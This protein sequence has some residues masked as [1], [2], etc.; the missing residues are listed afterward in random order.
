MDEFQNLKKNSTIVYDD[1]E[2]SSIVTYTDN[3]IPDLRREDPDVSSKYMNLVKKASICIF[4]IVI[5]CILGALSIRPEREEVKPVPKMPYIIEQ[6]YNPKFIEFRDYYLVFATMIKNKRRYVREW[7]EFHMMMGITYFLVYDNYSEDGTREL[8]E[9]YIQNGVVSYMLWPPKELPLYNWED[10]KLE[11]HFKV[12]MDTCLNDHSPD[13]NHVQCQEAAFDDATRRSRGK[14]KW[15]ASVDIDEFYYVPESSP[16]ANL[17]DPLPSV[18]KKLE[19]YKMIYLDGQHF[20]TSGFLSPARRNDD[21]SFASLIT[22][23]HL[24]HMPYKRAQLVIAGDH[25]KPFVDPYCV[26]G[27]ELHDYGYDEEWFKEFP[28][29]IMNHNTIAEENI[30]IYMNHFLWPSVSETAVKVKDNNN[31]GT[32]YDRDYDCVINKEEGSSIEYLL[33]RL[34]KR[35]ETAVVNFPPA[36]SHA[37]DWDFTLSSRHVYKQATKVDLCIAIMHPRHIGLVRHALTSLIYY[38][39]NV[40]PSL[41]YYLVVYD[42][43]PEFDKELRTDFPIDSFQKNA[44]QLKDICSS[45]EYILTMNEASFAR[46]EAWPKEL[47]VIEFALQLIYKHPKIEGVYLGDSKNSI[48]EWEVSEDNKKAVFRENSALLKTNGPML[49]KKTTNV[50]K[51]YEMCLQENL[52]CESNILHGLFEYYHQSRLYNYP[53]L[54]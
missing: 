21:Q 19:K 54:I 27:N 13:K 37:D 29:M 10:P 4:L 35:I 25:R 34:E 32:S 53:P 47:K 12:R 7:I 40:E 8:L 18:F 43:D 26:L 30:T 9:P 42:A 50:T 11:E 48:S 1:E 23:T 28:K 15:L 39:S 52:I 2:K 38:M 20:G 36:D 16:Y 46:W 45:G 22:K 14:A 49:A 24:H 3:T 41:N 33:Q 51:L 44:T 5:S 31:P 17:S 6:C